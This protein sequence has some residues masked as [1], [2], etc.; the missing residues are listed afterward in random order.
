[1]RDAF[2]GTK[3][4]AHE[5]EMY[6]TDY[7]YIETGYRINHDSCKALAKSLFHCHNETVNVWSHLFG[8]ILFAFICFVLWFWINP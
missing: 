3:Q 2:I 6:Q 4:D 8:V 7:D 1:M 5:S